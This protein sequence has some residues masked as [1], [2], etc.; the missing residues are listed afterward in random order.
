M[1]IEYHVRFGGQRAGDE[2]SWKNRLGPDCEVNLDVFYC[3]E[4]SS[5]LHRLQ[6]T[7]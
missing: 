6:T 4:E 5:M 1:T 7:L 3:S 2:V